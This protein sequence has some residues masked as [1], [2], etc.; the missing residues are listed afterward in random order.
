M[1]NEKGTMEGLI[2]KAYNCIYNNIYKYIIFVTLL[3]LLSYIF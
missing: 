1:M 3:L 2:K